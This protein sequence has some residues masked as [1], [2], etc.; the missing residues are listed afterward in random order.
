M[1]VNPWPADLALRLQRE[2]VRDVECLFADVTGYPRGKLMPAA[3]LCRR[4]RNCAS[5]RRC[6]CSV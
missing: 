2:G 1:S 6:R 3:A 5:R 4:A